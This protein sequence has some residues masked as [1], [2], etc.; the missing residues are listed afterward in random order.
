[1]KS[2]KPVPFLS[3]F[4]ALTLFCA[5]SNGDAV[6]AP[7]KKDKLC[8]SD[9]L[10]KIIHID[11]AGTDN[12]DDELKLSGEVSFNDNKVVKVF[13][14]SSGQVMEVKVS[15]GDKVAKGQT[16][17]VIRSADVAGNYSDLSTSG[18]DV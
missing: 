17:A 18:N 2:L 6:K 12:V 9:S 4:A 10:A 3:L 7:E 16:L 14:F 1:M 11:T 13:P 15:I 8:V 5:C